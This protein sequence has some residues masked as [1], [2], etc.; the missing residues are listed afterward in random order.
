MTIADVNFEL[1]N[2]FATTEV[3]MQSYVSYVQSLEST[4]VVCMQ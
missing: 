4:K 3:R 1:S 2:V